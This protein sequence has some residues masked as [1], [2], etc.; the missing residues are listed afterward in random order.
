MVAG[1]NAGIE[2]FILV[3]LGNKVIWVSSTISRRRSRRFSTTTSDEGKESILGNQGG[4]D[5]KGKKGIKVFRV[6]SV[7]RV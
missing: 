2:L 5:I 6:R 3:I 7:R 4:N 1:P